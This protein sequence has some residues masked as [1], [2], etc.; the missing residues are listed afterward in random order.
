VAS[1]FARSLLDL[2]AYERRDDGALVVAAGIPPAWLAGGEEVGVSGLGS[3]WGEISYSVR[4]RAGR[5]V[6]RIEALEG[7]PPG[8]V[9]LA[10]PLAE[11]ARVAVDGAPAEPSADGLALPALPATVVVEAPW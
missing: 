5:L 6:A 8:G 11:T 1:D 3:P 9:V 4:L 7:W 2:F 10:L